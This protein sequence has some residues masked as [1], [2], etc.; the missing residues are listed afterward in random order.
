[1]TCVAELHGSVIRMPSS[2]LSHIGN[3]KIRLCIKDV[4][5]K[6]NQ[7]GLGR[8]IRSLQH[9]SFAYKSTDPADTT[10]DPACNPANVVNVVRFILGTESIL[11]TTMRSWIEDSLVIDQQWT[12]FSILQGSCGN[13]RQHDIILAFFSDC[14]RG[15]SAR[16]D[17]SCSTVPSAPVAKVG[18]KKGSAHAAQR[19]NQ[20][21]W[22]QWSKLPP[23]SP[24]AA[25]AGSPLRQTGVLKVGLSRVLTSIR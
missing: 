4:M 16:V 14:D 2:I 15:S 1:M 12:P 13:W 6:S 20:A 3:S 7:G 10:P 17:W 19:L 8:R 23:S 18:L 21:R 24:R 25:T 11:D 9:V 5:D 22:L